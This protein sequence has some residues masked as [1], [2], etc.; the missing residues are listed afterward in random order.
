MASAGEG[1]E[2]VLIVTAGGRGIELEVGG[3]KGERQEDWEKREEGGEGM[4]AGWMFNGISNWLMLLNF[5]R[6]RERESAQDSERDK[7]SELSTCKVDIKVLCT[8]PSCGAQGNMLI[9]LL[10]IFCQG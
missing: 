2:C 8:L 9:C 10:A 4:H 6:E 5:A 3:D 7:T 1:C